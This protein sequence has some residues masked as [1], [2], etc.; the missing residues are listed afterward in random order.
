MQIN[1][2]LDFGKYKGLS[3]QK[4]YQGVTSIDKELIKQ[5]IKQKLTTDQS[6]DQSWIIAELLDFEISDTL[7]RATPFDAQINGNYEK[8]IAGLFK[9]G[10]TFLERLV[11]VTSFEEF[12]AIKK[13]EHNTNDICGGSPEYIN[14]CINTIE[15]FYIDPDDL[16][17]LIEMPVF[18]FKEMEVKFKIEDIYSYKPHFYTEQYQFPIPTVEKNRRKYELMEEDNFEEKDD[19]NSSDSDRDHFN[20]M[21]DGQLG[22][23]DDFEGNSDDIS[24]WSGR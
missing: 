16:E 13:G 23:Y 1:D 20:A 5:Y 7:I 11:G 17:E 10:T 18:R 14:W 9:K 2:Q 12:I 8:Q 3:L 22:D 21:S 19:D 4:I 6:V 24:N 15:W